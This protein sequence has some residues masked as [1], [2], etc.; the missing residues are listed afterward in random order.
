MFRCSVCKDVVRVINNFNGFSNGISF[1]IFLC[2]RVIGVMHQ[3]IK[4]ISKCLVGAAIAY[5]KIMLFSINYIVR[6]YLHKRVSVFTG[7]LVVKAWT[8]LQRDQKIYIS[9]TIRY[10]YNIFLFMLYIFYLWHAWTRVV[11]SLY[12]HTHRL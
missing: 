3:G 9:A 10:Y 2:K 6:V 1:I 8:Y 5:V 7:L 12:T 11:Q 4:I